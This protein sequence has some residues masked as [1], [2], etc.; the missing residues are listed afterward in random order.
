MV[1]SINGTIRRRTSGTVH[2]GSASQTSQPGSFLSLGLLIISLFCNF[3]FRFSLAFST[4]DVG[5]Y[6]RLG[7]PFKCR[8]HV[9]VCR[10]RQD[11]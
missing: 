7:I 4:P 10:P 8:V 2:T 5:L 6:R 9:C 11:T 3:N 1:C